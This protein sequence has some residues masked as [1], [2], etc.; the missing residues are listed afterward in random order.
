MPKLLGLAVS[1]QLFGQINAFMGFSGSWFRHL[2]GGLE[3]VTALLLACGLAMGSKTRILGPYGLYLLGL[4]LLAGTMSGAI[5]T[6]LIIRPGEDPT[7]T[8][9]AI[10]LF[11]ISLGLLRR[12][13]LHAQKHLGASVS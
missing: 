5:V 4:L 10:L 9:L 12:N 3:L 1:V 6:E 13:L 2:T 8:V 7:L 11:L